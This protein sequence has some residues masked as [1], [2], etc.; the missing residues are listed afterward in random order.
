MSI[1]RVLIPAIHGPGVLDWRIAFRIGNAA[2]E[3]HRAANGNFQQLRLLRTCKTRLHG[4]RDD[5]RAGTL[6]TR[7]Y[8]LGKTGQANQLLRDFMLAD[9]GAFPLFAIE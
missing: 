5:L 4:S 9:K 3:K 7:P 6:S 1:E 2:R 8:I